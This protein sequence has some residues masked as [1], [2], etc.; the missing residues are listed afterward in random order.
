MALID[1]VLPKRGVLLEWAY[2]GA[3]FA[4]L[5]WVVLSGGE[6]I[7]I[8]AFVAVNLSGLAVFDNYLVRRPYVL[9]GALDGAVSIVTNVAMVGLPLLLIIGDRTPWRSLLCFVVLLTSRALMRGQVPQIRR[10]RLR[11]GPN[12]P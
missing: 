10:R 3:C 8:V 9:R 11:G 6:P 5:L 2:E 12:T 4:A 1:G 7:P